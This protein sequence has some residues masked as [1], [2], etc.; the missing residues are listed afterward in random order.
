MRRHAPAA[1]LALLLAACGDEPTPPPAAGPVARVDGLPALV[2]LLPGD[3]TTLAV[4]AYDSAGRRVGAD[5]VRWT[6]RPDVDVNPLAARLAGGTADTR[7]VHALRSGHAAL[8]T[9]APDAPDRELTRTTIV[10]QPLAG[11]SEQTTVR[12]GETT[13]L[14]RLRPTVTWSLAA[15]DGIPTIGTL[16][17]DGRYTAPAAPPDTTWTEYPGRSAPLEY[18]GARPARTIALVRHRDAVEQV[19][20]TLVPARWTVR[21][22]GRSVYVPRGG[23][24][25]VSLPA[26]QAA[27]PLV[28]RVDARTRR[29]LP[30]APEWRSGDPALATVDSAGT[31]RFRRAGR[32]ELFARF[33]GV[34]GE[35]AVPMVYEGR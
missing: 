4:A 1:A 3:D 28:W 8:S 15:V 31:L 16:T 10:V 17:A 2:E 9:A 18:H 27:D 21:S 14:A 22:L 26:A 7:T 19:E 5:A 20:L 24:P 34:T 33:P 11:A 23:D 25:V 13:Q 29:P 6:I 35:V 30:D 12:F 32:G